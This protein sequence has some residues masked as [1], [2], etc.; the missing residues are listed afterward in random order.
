MIHEAGHVIADYFKVYED[1]EFVEILRSGLEGFDLD[2]VVDDMT[3][4]AEPISYLKNDKFVSIYQGRLYDDVYRHNGHR[5]NPNCLREYFS[6]G[7]REFV[8]T[9]IMLWSKI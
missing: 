5:L 9:Q 7:Y 1:D 4:F 6:E 2:D 3:T 8:V